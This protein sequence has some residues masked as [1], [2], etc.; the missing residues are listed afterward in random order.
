MK[1]NTETKIEKM[2]QLSYDQDI[3]F[4]VVWSFKLFKAIQLFF[5]LNVIFNFCGILPSSY[6]FYNISWLLYLLEFIFIDTW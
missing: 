1:N 5:V 4:N 2:L 6:A 3:F